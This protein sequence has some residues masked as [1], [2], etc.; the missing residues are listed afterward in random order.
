MLCSTHI[1]L[2][3]LAV[4]V[5]KGSKPPSTKTV[6]VNL[7]ST[8]TYQKILGFGGALT[9]SVAYLFNTMDTQLKRN[10]FD[11][12]FNQNKGL[13][14]TFLRTSIGGCDFDLEPWAYNES[15]ANDV[16]LSNFTELD[17]RDK[18]KVALLKEI[19][20]QTGVQ[21]KLLGT[22]W[23]SPTWMKTNGAWT[24]WSSLKS[25][26]YEAWAEYHLKFLSLMKQE[27]VSLWAISTGNEPMNGVMWFLFVRFMSLGWVPKEQGRWVADFLG[28][29]LKNFSD[30]VLLLAGDDQ[31]YTFPWWFNQVYL[32]SE[33]DSFGSYSTSS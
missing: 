19:E 14:F 18:L 31:R 10:V 27:N 4:S 8:R 2:L 12:Y 11:A 32:R 33:F 30:K 13:G 24:G 6:V 1:F 7:N 15:P 5:F 26:Y 25:E 21:I 23:S 20:A 9:G 17:A 28:P 22:A 3:Q 16:K 29:K